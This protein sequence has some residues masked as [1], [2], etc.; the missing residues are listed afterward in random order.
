MGNEPW[1]YPAEFYTQILLGMASGS[2]LCKYRSL[3]T[4]ILGAKAGDS[5][6]F[7]VP[8]ALQANSA[9]TTNATSG[10]YVGA[11]VPQEAVRVSFH[12]HIKQI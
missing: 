7:V 9:E 3:I 4:C 5:E 2:I 11:R 12:Y 6:L 10:S 1:D 8:C